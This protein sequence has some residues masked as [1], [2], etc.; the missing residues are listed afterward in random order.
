MSGGGA[1]HATWHLTH[2]HVSVL[3]VL[4]FSSY[5]KAGYPAENIRIAFMAERTRRNEWLA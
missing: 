2:V 4:W 3:P 5:S 1:T